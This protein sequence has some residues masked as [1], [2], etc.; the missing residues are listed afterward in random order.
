[1]GEL[2]TLYLAFVLII[3]VQRLIELYISNKNNKALLRQG[4]IEFG[5]GHFIYMKL[6]HI[7]W[8]CSCFLGGV[9][10]SGPDLVPYYAF[11]LFFMGQIL[12]FLAMLGLANRWTANIIILPGFTPVRKGIYKFIRHPN[13]LGVVLEIAAL[14]LIWGLYEVAIVFSI[15]NAFILKVRIKA[16]EKALNSYNKYTENMHTK[17]RFLPGL[18]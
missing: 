16:E 15:L 9:Y 12:R 17:R 18:F 7:L 1:M 5:Q 13:Y 6:I 11:T 8:L 2:K 10:Y 4:G 3:G 14:P